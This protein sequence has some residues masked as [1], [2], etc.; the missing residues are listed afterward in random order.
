MAERVIDVDPG[1]SWEP[2]G[3]EGVLV[4]AEQGT[5]ALRLPANID[6]EDQSWVCLAW[7][8]VWAARMEPPNDEARAGHRL[9]DAGLREVVWMGEVVDSVLI[10]DLER[11]NRVHPN[12]SPDRYRELR[13]WILPLKG[14][15]VEVVGTG[16]GVIRRAKRG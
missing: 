2:N 9:Y 15:V 5:A 10:E 16:F 8:G 1:V 4:V 6:D 13:H 14:S 3:E 7:E 11:R 12:H